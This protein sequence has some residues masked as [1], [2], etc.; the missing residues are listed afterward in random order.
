VQTHP[1]HL[2]GQALAQMLPLRPLYRMSPLPMTRDHS[3]TG[4]SAETLPRDPIRRNEFTHCASCRGTPEASALAFCWPGT[5]Y[6]PHV[7][8]LA[9]TVHLEHSY[10]ALPA[11]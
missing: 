3:D 2:A 7:V 5:A 4:F 11:R 9:S 6:R 8:V 10:S 1:G